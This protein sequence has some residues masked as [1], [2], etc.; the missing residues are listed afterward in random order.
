MANDASPQSGRAAPGKSLTTSETSSVRARLYASA[1]AAHR[2]PIG[3]NR[4]ACLYRPFWLC[5]SVPMCR[6]VKLVGYAFARPAHHRTTKW[7]DWDRHLSCRRPLRHP[8]EWAFQA[9]TRHE[10]NLLHPLE[11]PGL[12]RARSDRIGWRNC[13]S[14]C[15]LSRVLWPEWF[16]TDAVAAAPNV[17]SAIHELAGRDQQ[18]G[19]LC[20]VRPRRSAR[21]A[22]PQR[23]PISGSRIV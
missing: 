3:G 2:S 19:G 8:S 20:T 16:A 1:L 14:A 6:L 12:H 9:V 10:S 21:L 18:L 4:L 15:R 5:R 23:R 13:R 22:A 17:E 11:N 7:R